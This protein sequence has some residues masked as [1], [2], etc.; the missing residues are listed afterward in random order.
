MNEHEK[1][2]CAIFGV[3]AALALYYAMSHDGEEVTPA[4]QS[5]AQVMGMGVSAGINYGAGT[6]LDLRPDVHF[7]TPGHDPDSSACGVI[8]TPHR[9]PAIP[10]GNISTVMHKGW[11]SMTAS[12][13][14]NDWFYNPPEAAV[15]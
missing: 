9:Y 15:L 5:E 10:G 3:G 8:T 7:W 2:V 4:V 14:D 13:P 12:S 6:P 1:A 11:G